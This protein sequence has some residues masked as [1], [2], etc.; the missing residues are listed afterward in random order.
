MRASVRE[1]PP[2]RLHWEIED[3][4]GRFAR[5][6]GDQ[7]NPDDA[8]GDESFGTTSPGGFEA[9]DIRLPR[10]SN[11][12]YPDLK[13]LGTI[14]ARG[15]GNSIA[16]EGRIER[17][18][19]TTNA[20]E[21][22]INPSAVGWQAA[23]EDDQSAC[24]IPV[25]RLASS[26]GE[27]SLERRDALAGAHVD[28][29]DV[30]WSSDQEG[31]VAE[32]PSQD[33]P[34]IVA[35]AMYGAPSGVKLARFNYKGA[36]VSL[37]GGH[38]V[39]VYPTDDPSIGSFDPGLTL[40]LDDTRRTQDLT[41]VAA[42]RY[43]LLQLNGP[44]VTPTDGALVRFEEVAVYG[45]HNIPL[46]DNA[47]GLSGVYASDVIKWALG[48]T[49][50]NY[51]DDTIATSNFLIEHLPFPDRTTAAEMV[52]QA[53]RFHLTPWYV[54]EG[55]TFWY[56][57]RSKAW[58]TRTAPCALE[59]TGPQ[60]DRVWNSIIVQFTDVDGT[61]KTVGPP[62]S[63]ADYESTALV[64]DDP[65]NPSN[66]LGIQRRALL[67]LGTGVTTEAEQLGRIFLQATKE[68]DSS[69]KADLVG[70]VEDDRGVLWP[71]WMVRAGDTLE[72]VDAR[73]RAPRRIVKT[74]YSVASATNT[75]D[76]DSP[77][78]GLQAI[79]ERMDVTFQPILQS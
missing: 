74:A 29:T 35:E 77:P 76:L 1:K 52:K 9:S 36:A 75:V 69:G 14:R 50:L 26:F 3:P 31:L 66:K 19:A 39:K 53:N 62:G 61:T 63:G 28:Y 21:R 11:R 59:D 43:L 17:S 25:D 15:V 6:A 40:T 24:G 45:D 30:S 46:Q 47:F 41:G 48:F 7:R 58:R 72:V 70:W 71:S 10:N 23:L 5:W 44:A 79:Q 54:W 78:E 42:R 22:S 32:Y 4:D 27:I 64:D 67:T 49:S 16:W 34:G 38:A 65:A 18:P 12:D 13:G 56:G 51:T 20:Q 57:E 60:V 2:I 33:L 55:K 73:N 8:P 68:L 37:P